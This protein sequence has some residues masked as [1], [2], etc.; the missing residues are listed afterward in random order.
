MIDAIGVPLMRET[1]LPLDPPDRL[2]IELRPEI[3]D[4]RPLLR[5]HATEGLRELTVAPLEMTVLV[6]EEDRL[7]QRVHRIVHDIIHITDNAHTIAFKSPFSV[8]TA[9]P[10]KRDKHSPEQEGRSAHIGIVAE[11]HKR[12]REHDDQMDRQ[13]DPRG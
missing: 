9:L 2:E 8:T 5:L 10:R 13:V 6:H 12:K 7:R 1:I 4:R 3:H 11:R